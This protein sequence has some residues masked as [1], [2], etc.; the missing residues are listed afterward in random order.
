[1]DSDADNLE[2]DE[3]DVNENELE[4]IVNEEV[5]ELLLEDEENDIFEQSFIGFNKENADDAEQMLHGYG[6]A[7]MNFIDYLCL[8]TEGQQVLTFA[9]IKIEKSPSFGQ[10]YVAICVMPCDSYIHKQ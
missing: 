9:N 6:V 3:F 2:I 4:S 5:P 10:I 1:M 7:I 8:T